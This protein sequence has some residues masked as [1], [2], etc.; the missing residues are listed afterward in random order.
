M[1]RQGS[2]VIAVEVHQANGTSSDTWLNLSMSAKLR[3]PGLSDSDHFYLTGDQLFINKSVTEAGREEGDFFT[4]PVVST[5]DLGNEFSGQVS[6][7]VG[8]NSKSP[9]DSISLTSQEL[10]EQQAS[11]QVIGQ[12]SGTDPEGDTITFAVSLT[13]II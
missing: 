9:P 8:P 7:R 10:L 12:L 1:L 4:V 11:G 2:N 6:I 3:I 5:D 13:L